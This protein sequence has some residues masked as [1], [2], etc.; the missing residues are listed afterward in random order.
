MAKKRGDSPNIDNC[1]TLLMDSAL[2]LDRGYIEITARIG[3]ARTGGI[4]SSARTKEKLAP[5]Q[6]ATSFRLSRLVL[7]NI[8]LHSSVVVNVVVA[9]WIRNTFSAS[10]IGA[11]L[12]YLPHTHTLIR[13]HQDHPVYLKSDVRRG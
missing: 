9:K 13:A 7:N 5:F 8:A 10:F 12:L 11:V 6:W 2:E 1:G 4:G 3:A